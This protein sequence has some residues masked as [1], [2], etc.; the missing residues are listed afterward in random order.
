[1]ITITLKEFNEILAC[2]TYGRWHD[3]ADEWDLDD[4]QIV[5]LAN[6]EKI[7]TEYGSVLEA[8]ID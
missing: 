3:A 2:E 1:M 4:W 5:K 6:G 7:E 8:K